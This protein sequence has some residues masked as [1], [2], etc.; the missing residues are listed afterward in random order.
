M[1]GLYYQH[2]PLIPN[3]L[4]VVSDQIEA[5]SPERGQCFPIPGLQVVPED[6]QIRRTYDA[7]AG[8]GGGGENNGQETSA[9]KQNQGLIKKCISS[10]NME[11]Q[12]CFPMRF[13]N[14]F[15]SRMPCDFLSS[16]SK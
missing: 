13:W 7:G 14:S 10:Q 2:N 12:N 3:A 8:S 15:R 4:W 5:L 16:L 1:R 11:P 6:N 9:R